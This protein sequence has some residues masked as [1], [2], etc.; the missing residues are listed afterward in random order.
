MPTLPSITKRSVYSFVE[1]L[2]TF[3]TLTTHSFCTN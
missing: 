3:K 2:T 1:I